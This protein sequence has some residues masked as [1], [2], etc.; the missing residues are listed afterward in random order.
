[1]HTELISI[2]TDTTPLDGAYYEPADRDPVGAVIFFHG[3]TMN[4]YVGPP[5]FLPPA[6]TG[7]GFACLAVNRRGHDILSVR[8]SKENIEGAAFQTTAEALADHELAAAWLADRGFPA[9]IVVAHSN[10]GMMAPPFVLAHP[11]TPALV[12]LSAG[13]GGPATDQR[14]GLL[15]GG[16]LAEVRERATALVDA[17]RGRELMMVPGW[18]YLITAE[19]FLDRITTVPDLL[20]AAPRITCPVLYVRGDRESAHQFPGDEYRA[21]AGG[22]CEVR[23]V[24]DCDHFYNGRT[25]EVTELVCEFVTRTM[26]GVRDGAA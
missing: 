7:L 13:R 15:A 25:A 4:F 18:W 2:A 17:G 14:S 20:A 23:V 22:P 9:P 12:L 19:S 16:S 8:D 24:P 26:G 3:N 11:D 5:R 10:G 21:R 1:V 6:L